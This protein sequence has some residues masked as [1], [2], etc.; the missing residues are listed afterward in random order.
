[1]LRL[2]MSPKDLAT[3]QNLKVERVMGSIDKIMQQR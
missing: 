1:V 3:S 2:I